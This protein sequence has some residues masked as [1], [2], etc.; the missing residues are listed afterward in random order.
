MCDVVG[1]A[2]GWDRMKDDRDE[3]RHLPALL[4]QY[5]YTVFWMPKRS[6]ARSLSLAVSLL[7]ADES[8]AHAG[9]IETRRQRQ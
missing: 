3:R 8:D 9:S 7:A 1:L 5:R 6:P 4:R 2:H